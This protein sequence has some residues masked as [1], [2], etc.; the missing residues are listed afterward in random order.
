M[1]H[2]SRLEELGSRVTEGVQPGQQPV[3]SFLMGSTKIAA[4][5]VAA[6]GT[7]TVGSAAACNALGIYGFPGHGVVLLYLWS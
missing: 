5:I 1:R 4:A 2:E 7:T 6:H 3:A